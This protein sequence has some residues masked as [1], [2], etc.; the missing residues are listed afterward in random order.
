MQLQAFADVIIKSHA[1][2]GDVLTIEG[3]ATTPRTD[4]VNDIVE[5][6]GAKFKCPLPLNMH[7]KSSE[8]VGNVVRAQATQEGIRF[9]AELPYVKEP[10]RVKDRV[11]EAIHSIKH[12]LLNF[13]SIGA[14]PHDGSIEF[15]KNGGKRYKSWEWLHLALCAE[16]ANPDAMITA[17]KS[18]NDT[19]RALSSKGVVSLSLSAEA[20]PSTSQGKQMNLNDSLS[21]ATKRRDD[22][23]NEHRAALDVMLEKGTT[24]EAADQE[25]QNKRLEDLEKLDEHIDFLKRSEA[26]LSK[27][28]PIRSNGEGVEIGAGNFQF[29]KL[30]KEPGIAFAQ[31]LRCMY[32]SNGSDFV[33]RQIAKEMYRD[34]PRI[35]NLFKADVPAAAVTQDNWGQDFVNT[36][37][38]PFAEF[39]EYVRPLT[40]VGRLTGATRV[41]FL[42]PVGTM[43]GGGEGYWVGEGIA[44]PLTSF[45]ASITRLPPTK[46]ANIVPVTEE[47]LKYASGGNDRRIRDAMAGALQQRLDEDFVDPTVTLSAGV[48]PASIT[49]GAATQAATGTGD[50]ADI[51]VDFK[52]MMGVIST[53]GIRRSPVLIVDSA[54]ALALGMMINTF[55]QKVFPDMSMTGGTFL[56]GVQVIVSDSVPHASAGGTAILVNAPEILI[57]DEGGFDIAMSRDASL[58]MTD[59]DPQT[60]MSSVP[61]NGS[62]A[63]V[64][65]FQTNSVAFRAERAIGWLRARTTAVAYVTAVNWGAA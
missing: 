35:A 15:M 20:A 4:R 37:G 49:Q 19:Q 38:G 50:H 34:D 36:D 24:L 3:I 44:K 43:T 7:H 32:K 40:I 25:Q 53:Q 39:L 51:I 10:G 47:W 56:A 46:V 55:G 21:A 9:W 1:V 14:R 13:V 11:D 8:I 58:L 5:S 27:A 61:V 29:Q 31:Y 52:Y 17:I 65:M 62:A 60:D 30:N 33:A 45:A 63:M 16:P 18:F 23:A 57:A 28:K 12:K 2:S 64:S 54:T 59:T 6:M 48:R 41:D 26:T 22:L 42:K